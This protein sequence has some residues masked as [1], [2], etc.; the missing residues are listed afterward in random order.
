MQAQ[1]DMA[2][3]DH[4]YDYDPHGRIYHPASADQAPTRSTTLWLVL[5]AGAI[6][7]ALLLYLTMR[8]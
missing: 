6:V 2:G 8:P 4:P 7:L 5:L 3:A 1:S